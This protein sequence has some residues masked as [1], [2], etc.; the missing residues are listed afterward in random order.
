MNKGVY[1]KLQLKR[2][3]RYYPA[4]LAV[5][6]L[7]AF[8]VS[9]VAAMLLKTD[10]QKNADAKRKINLGLVGDISGTYLGVGIETIKNI[11][12]SALSINFIALSKAEAQRQL[13]SGEL[14]A[15][16][17]IPDDFVKA[18]ESGENHP[19]T[20]VT[21]DGPTSFGVILLQEL[22]GTVSGM[23]TESQSAIY[24]M[25]DL[26][27]QNG[28]YPYDKGTELSQEY[29]AFMLKRS[30]SCVR[31]LTGAKDGISTGAYYIAGILV[32][33]LLLWGVT[34]SAFMTRKNDTLSRVL[35]ARGCGSVLQ[36]AAEY[37]AYVIPGFVTLG[38]LFG[39][40]GLSVG[41]APL[42]ISEISG[43]SFGGY[44]LLA[45][46]L[47]PVFLM[48]AALQYF[49]YEA[50]RG[51]V[52]ALLAQFLIAVGLG[53]ISGC[54]YPNNFFPLSVQR[55]AAML[56]SG[57]AFTYA[58]RL[59]SGTL[60]TEMAIPILLYTALFL[61]L[62]VAIRKYRIAGKRL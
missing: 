1:F 16:A 20:F 60:E 11:D 47:F 50:I 56:P 55:L 61:G 29:I 57:V 4:V 7:L 58:R 42:S 44:V 12:S 49:L 30:E 32:F 25:Q 48:I 52:P 5:T 33:F 51:T 14:L 37:L 13:R 40:V 27:D 21:A 62:S 59:L 26:L 41:G 46:R 36:T 24:G 17:E 10:D 19:L 6:I 3:F 38:I 54:F 18:I 28:I 2:A 45:L 23:V 9:L 43:I 39:A 8:G 34:C 53:Y 35:A 15:Y 31:D 22:I